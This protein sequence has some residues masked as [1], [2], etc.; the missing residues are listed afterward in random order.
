VEVT[1]DLVVNMPNI[2]EN[3]ANLVE[4]ATSTPFDFFGTGQNVGGIVAMFLVP[5][6]ENLFMDSLNDI[7][8]FV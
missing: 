2:I 8:D 3:I 4:I 6:E 7:C 5:G 1:D